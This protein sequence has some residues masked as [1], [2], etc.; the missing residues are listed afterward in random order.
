MHT[1]YLL[2]DFVIFCLA[3]LGYRGAAF[4]FRQKI[5]RI[6]PK[7]PQLLAAIKAIALIGSFY[8]IWDQAVTN[9]WWSF[10][11]SYING[12]LIG[13]LPIEEVL[14]FAIVPWSCLVIWVNLRQKF[15][16]KVSLP[17][18]EALIGF[19]LVTGSWQLFLQHYYTVTICFLAI[20]TGIISLKNHHWLRQKNVLLFGGITLLLTAIFNSY[21][22]SLPIVIY[23]THIMTNLRIFTIPVEDFIYGWVL[24]TG[25]IW[26]YERFSR[27]PSGS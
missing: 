4:A 27:P 6:T 19:S 22:T 11:P 23:N 25:T 12:Q 15:S 13:R 17:I 10:N 5:S 3:D 18:E 1:H 7:Q 2:F 24:I 16:K 26:F 21:L 20:V 9:W 8:F 14:F